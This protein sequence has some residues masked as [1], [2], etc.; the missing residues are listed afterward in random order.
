MLF[1]K[2]RFYCPECKRFLDRRKVTADAFDEIY[3]CKFHE[4]PVIQTRFVV[5]AWIEE[6]ILKIIEKGA[7]DEFI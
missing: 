7:E 3:F 4:C 2:H 6:M 1:G 5:E